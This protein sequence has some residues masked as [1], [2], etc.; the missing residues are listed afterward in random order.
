MKRICYI[1]I[2]L[3]FFQLIF[4]GEIIINENPLEVD[5]LEENF[6][7]MVLEYNFGRFQTNSVK[8]DNTDYLQLKL[9]R[10]S[11]LQKKGFPALPTI[12]R[13]FII[14]DN[15]SPEVQIIE[16]SFVEYVLDIAPSKG[17]ILRSENPQ[18]IPY[19]FNEIY[20]ENSFFPEELAELSDPYIL[21]DFRGVM[22]TVNPFSYNPVTRT[23]RVYHQIKIEINYTDTEPV[24]P[25]KSLT[26]RYCY[27]F[28]PIYKSHFLNFNRSRYTPV[29]E[30]GRMLVISHE[31]FLDEMQPYVDWKI[32]KGIETELINVDDIGT[33]AE[34]IKDYLITEYNSSSGLTFVQLVGDGYHVPT[35]FSGSSGLDPFYSL[36]DGS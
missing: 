15:G 22:I 33:T 6:T 36:I 25:K 34:E 11:N 1:F 21:R 8:I 2:F 24:N 35:F 3:I 31:D 23:L 7:G 26:D 13:S 14:T 29:E 12:N 5:I 4:A 32:Q 10:E 9:G 18:E 30:A 28:E 17:E 27:E 19:I 16:S 20:Q